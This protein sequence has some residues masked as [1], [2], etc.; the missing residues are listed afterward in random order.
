MTNPVLTLLGNK[1]NVIPL[2][3]PKAVSVPTAPKSDFKPITLNIVNDTIQDKVIDTVMKNDVP[4]SL[5][6]SVPLDSVPS[7]GS[8][9]TANWKTILGLVN[10][11]VN[12]YGLAINS[13]LRDPKTA[14][15]TSAKHSQHYLGKAVDLG[16]INSLDDTTR[17][18]LV[19]ELYNSGFRGFG[20]GNTILHADMG[21]KRYWTYDDTGKWISGSGWG[22]PI[23][24]QL[25]Y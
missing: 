16:G 4:P 17:S 11:I 21:P 2:K 24:K 10:P 1:T 15:P 18:Q 12:K 23:V 14:G 3:A 13:G 20:F 8:D 22:Q 19:R 25:G 7:L 9:A 6:N 5:P